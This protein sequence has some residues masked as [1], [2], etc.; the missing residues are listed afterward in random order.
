MYLC[1]VILS[2]VVYRENKYRE[3]GCLRAD[4]KF[5]KG[6]AV[7]DEYDTNFQVNCMRM[8]VIQIN[9]AAIL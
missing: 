8:T 2:D 9:T 7:A 3:R 1:R 5:Q 4:N 6:K